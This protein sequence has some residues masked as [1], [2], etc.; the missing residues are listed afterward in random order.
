[1]SWSSS[2]CR[3]VRSVH[4]CEWRTVAQKSGKSRQGQNPSKPDIQGE[5]GTKHVPERKPTIHDDRFTLAAQHTQ[6]VLCDDE[7]DEKRENRNN[8]ACW[9]DLSLDLSLLTCTS[10]IQVSVIVNT[11][12]SHPPYR[13]IKRVMFIATDRDISIHYC[14]RY[15]LACWLNSLVAPQT[16]AQ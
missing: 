2:A 3:P 10:S 5:R 15:L 13:H 16:R 14:Q 12:C 1:M 9:A 8:S 4:G 11:I 6:Q 7:T